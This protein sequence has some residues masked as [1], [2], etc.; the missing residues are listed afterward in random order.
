MGCTCLD[1]CEIHS[2]RRQLGQKRPKKMKLQGSLS[3]NTQLRQILTPALIHTMQTFQWSYPQLVEKI[4][5]ESQENIFLEI[6][7]FDQ[8]LEEASHPY[9]KHC[10]RS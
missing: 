6:S 7:Q 3:L 9:L 10:G 5:E 4:T 1:R 8:L 2:F